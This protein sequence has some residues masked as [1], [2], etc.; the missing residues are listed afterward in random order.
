MVFNS[1]ALGVGNMS[2]LNETDIAMLKEMI[3]GSTH[4]GV[5]SEMAGM[6]DIFSKIGLAICTSGILW[7]I[8]SVSS[9]QN[10]NGV[11]SVKI[12]AALADINRIKTDFSEQNKEIFSERDFS[13]QITPLVQRLDFYTNQITNAVSQLDSIKNKQLE[14]STRLNHI[15]ERLN[16]QVNRTDN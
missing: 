14:Y 13:A 5:K 10:D 2:G 9:L 12:E 15:E 16:G 11:L 8:S 3:S 1:E 7:L 4:K 6:I